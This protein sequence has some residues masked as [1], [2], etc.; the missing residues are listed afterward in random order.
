MIPPLL[1][2]EPPLP[3]PVE[4]VLGAAGAGDA[5]LGVAAAGTEPIDGSAGADRVTLDS[6]DAAGEESFLMVGPA[7]PPSDPAPD[8]AKAPPKTAAATTAMRTARLGVT[9]TSCAACS[10]PGAGSDRFA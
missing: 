10:T 4:P 1:P 9:G 2:L 5:W 7:D 8:T 3:L 6:I